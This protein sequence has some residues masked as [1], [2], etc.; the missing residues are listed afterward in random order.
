MKYY[1]ILIVDDEPHIVTLLLKLLDSMEDMDLDVYYAYNATD[2]LEI[3]KKGSIDL[4]ITD[5]KMPGTTGLELLEEVNR[6]G[7]GT[8]AI[9]LTAY[10]DFQYAYEAF[11]ESTSRWVLSALLSL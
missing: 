5:I 3:I 4:L 2:A 8:K 9:L 6:R 10:P 1:C 7:Q 11:R